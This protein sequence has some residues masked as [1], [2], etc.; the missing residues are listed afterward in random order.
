M[1]LV[2]ALL[3]SLTVTAA[4]A[5]TAVAPAAQ[6][7][8]PAYATVQLGTQEFLDNMPVPGGQSGTIEVTPGS[9]I[10]LSAP[11]YI[12]V[13]PTA[14]DPSPQIWQFAFWD[15]G[16]TP[17]LPTAGHGK[18]QQST[19]VKF[20]APSGGTFDAT[21]WY[22]PYGGGCPADQICPPSV[23][24]VVFNESQDKP[25]PG[26]NPIAKV[27]PGSALMAGTATVS[28]DGVSPTIY[29]Q[30]C[31]G[32]TFEAQK[33]PF[34]VHGCSSSQVFST[35]LGSGTSS[36]ADKVPAGDDGYVIAVTD[37]KPPVKNTTTTGG[38]G[39]KMS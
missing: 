31:V 16:A 20:K 12:Y 39:T 7:K 9:T 6:A 4:M 33:G 30:T 22:L 37:Y 29:A 13:P 2:K 5:A 11:A 17:S 35:W 10:N 8:T 14:S 18:A 1:R 26:L 34:G 25:V 28:T 23:T 32:G 15:T 21:A 3:M 24:A 36:T 19:S 27:K 38:S